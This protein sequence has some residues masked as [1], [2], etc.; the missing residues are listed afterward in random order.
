M[1]SAA[2]LKD[3][4]F[5]A[6]VK[7]LQISMPDTELHWSEASG[8]G[9][10]LFEKRS[11]VEHLN[12]HLLVQQ[13]DRA[14]RIEIIWQASIA[15]TIARSCLARIHMPPGS[16]PHFETNDALQALWALP[17]IDR[18]LIWGNQLD[19]VALVLGFDQNLVEHHNLGLIFTS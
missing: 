13:D 1:S 4:P 14:E 9:A 18:R 2:A 3:R 12:D 7:A 5:L 6:P 11:A 8:M 10:G 17:D 15:E 19:P 16:W